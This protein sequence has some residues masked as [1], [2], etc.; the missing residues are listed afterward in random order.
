MLEIKPVPAFNDN[1]IWLIQRIGSTQV[2]VV[3]PGSAEAVNHYLQQHQLQ[4]TGILITHHH[5]D[6]TGGV[7]S[8][9][10]QH[11]VQAY[12]AAVTHCTDHILEQD[13]Q[14]E[15]LGYSFKTLSVPGHT[16]DHL[17]FY[18]ADQGILFSGD[19]LFFA[20]CGR[21]FEGSAAQM[22]Q[23]LAKLSALPDDTQVYCTHEYT[24]ANLKFAAAVEPNNPHVLQAMQQVA[25]LRSQAQ[26]SLPTTIGAEKCHNPFLRSQ[27][28]A[29]IGAA[30]EHAGDLV[31]DP[32]DVFAT[33]RQWKDNF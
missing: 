17:A 16:L 26:P 33:I 22:Y 13:E 11:A 3:D 7:A 28:P 23:S 9:K 27:E 31:I 8:L 5:Q 19:T 6:H 20:G 29:L 14:I 4:L 24:E 10:A 12:G 15:I 21:L 18:N 32:I 30:T 2:W 1:Y 25:Q